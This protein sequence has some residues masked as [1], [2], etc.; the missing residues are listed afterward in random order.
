MGIWKIRMR[1]LLAIRF[2]HIQRL[3]FYGLLAALLFNEYIIYY[4]NRLGWEKA[5]CETESCSRILFVAD[6]QV[7][8]ESKESRWYARYDSDK[9]ISR[10]YHQAVSHVR[11]DVIVFLGDLIDEGSFVDDFLYE[12][13]FRRFVEIFPEPTDVKMIFIPGDNDIGGEGSEMVKPSKVKRFNNY[14]EDNSQWKF[15]NKLNIYHINR[16][17]HELPLLKDQDMPQIEENSGYTRILISHFSIILIPGAYSYK[18]IERFRPHV[19]FSGHYHR[20]SQI[21][22]E[23]KRLRY[24]TTLPLMH[25]MSYELRTIETNQEAL[26]IQVPSC[27]YR[28]GEDH[29]GFGQAV[30]ENGYLHYTPLF[31]P[32]RFTQLRLYVVFGFVLIIVNILISHSFRK[33]LRKFNLTRQNYHPI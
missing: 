28:M 24:S 33:L 32:N 21:T 27:S 1:K 26:E 31:I 2:S 11:P 29:I 6:P 14:F 13:Y 9:H 4:F 3:N 30:I 19:I 25:S 7:L 15:D 22:S 10:N 20:S 5:A 8:G 23:L 12:K 17:T 16:I 18:A